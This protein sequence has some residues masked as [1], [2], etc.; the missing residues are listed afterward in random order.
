MQT[1]IRLCAYVVLMVL[2]AGSLTGLAAQEYRLKTEIQ[3]GGDGGWDYIGIDPAVRRLYFPHGNKVFI[4]D[5]DKNSVVGGIADTIA[6]SGIAVVT[7]LGRAFTRHGGPESGV[8]IV[9]LKTS[10]TISKVGTPSPD[11]LMYEPGQKEV[12]VFNRGT[13][14]SATVIDAAS[15]KVVATIPVGGLPEASAADPKVHRVYLNIMDKNTVLA[16]D[17]Q[18]HKQV[19]TWPVAPCETPIGMAIDRERHRL[20]VTCR[21]K[22]PVMVMMDTTNGKVLASVPIGSGVDGAGFDPAT[23]LAFSPSGGSTSLVGGSRE[24]PAEGGTLTIAKEETP[25]KLTIVQTLK[26]PDGVRTIAVD[27]KTHNIYLPAAKFEP[28][29]EGENRP[30]IIPGSVTVLVYSMK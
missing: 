16:L 15:G 26:T 25:G 21:G 6:L 18:M 7:E 9:D 30:R 27:T 23:R 12:W 4:I 19:S 2:A 24:N 20:F 13:A 17:T 1:V 14:Q 11:Y 22:K 28:I 10:Q 5:T 8:S 3:V 29:K